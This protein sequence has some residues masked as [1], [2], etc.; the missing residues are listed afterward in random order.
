MWRFPARWYAVSLCLPVV[1][2]IIALG[3]TLV[4]TP[5]SIA[6]STVAVAAAVVPIAALGE[7]FGWR[8][9]ALPRLLR[10]F[11]PVRA[12]VVL[13]FLWGIWHLPIFLLQGTAIYPAPLWASFPLFVVVV[14]A[15]SVLIGW[16]YGRTHGSLLA[17]ILFHQGIRMAAVVPLAP[18]LIAY[19]IY[20]AVHVLAAFVV[21]RKDSIM[22]SLAML[23]DAPHRPLRRRAG[24]R[25][26]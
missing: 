9:Y 12:S 6:F 26:S 7:E 24:R 21:S 17:A 2:A 3:L 11:S 1:L 18:G 15:E 20:A 23:K 19:G 5:G 16:V 22:R 13:G 8:G 4:Y 14:V 25:R 10:R